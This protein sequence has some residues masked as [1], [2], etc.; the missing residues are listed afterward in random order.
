MNYS[1]LWLDHTSVKTDAG[2]CGTVAWSGGSARVK[3][4]VG[5]LKT[6]LTAMTGR[7]PK[8]IESADFDGKGIL[9]CAEGEG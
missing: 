7:E 5:E 2:F 3:N 9:L 1:E 8:L 6:A 4:A